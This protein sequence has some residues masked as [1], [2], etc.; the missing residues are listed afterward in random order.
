MCFLRV[1]GTTFDAD[2]YLALSGLTA[3]S[4]YRAGEPRRPSKPEGQR[5][6]TSGFSVD[7]SDATWEDVREQVKDAIAFL[8]E[9]EE[10]IKMLRAAPGVEDMRLDF[11]VDLRID[12]VHIFG[13]YDYFPP[14]L[15][16]RAGALG[17]GLELSIYP[18][19]LMELSTRKAETKPLH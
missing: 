18:Q 9:H 4:V 6:Q 1:A 3:E 10:A 8:D 5:N 16:A 17:L 7:V 2:K 13:Q 14:E 19:D 12:R 15:V 11:A